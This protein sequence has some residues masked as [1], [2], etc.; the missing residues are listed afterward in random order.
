MSN[1]EIDA[2]I[3]QSRESLKAL[4]EMRRDIEGREMAHCKRI[5][6]LNEQKAAQSI[7]RQGNPF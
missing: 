5:E 7:P 4:R 3:Q 1:H 2:M 6:R